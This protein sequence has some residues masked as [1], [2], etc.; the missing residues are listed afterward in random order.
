MNF[1]Y[2]KSFSY[3]DLIKV[4]NLSWSVI[5]ETGPVKIYHYIKSCIF[6][7][8]TEDVGERTTSFQESTY[9]SELQTDCQHQT[10]KT[11]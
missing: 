5:S 10:G 9:T 8:V 6:F 2:S 7:I 11:K 1:S 4:L 3:I